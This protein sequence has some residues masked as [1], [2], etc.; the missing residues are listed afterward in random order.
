MLQVVENPAAHEDV[1]AQLDATERIRL[2]AGRLAAIEA[3]AA[4]VGGE[5]LT[6]NPY[7]PLRE[8]A[9]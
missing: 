7:A 8:A 6:D 2:G 4:A 1:L 9:R 3:V 5:R